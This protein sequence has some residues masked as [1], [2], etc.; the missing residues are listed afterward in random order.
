VRQSG[1][2]LI[3]LVSGQFDVPGFF[4]DAQG[5][6][7]VDERQIRMDYGIDVCIQVCREWYRCMRIAET[8]NGIGVYK[9]VENGI[10][11]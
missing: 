8:E 4:R 7:M 6:V 9:C 3:W 2:L 10:V 11:V 5:G 1:Y